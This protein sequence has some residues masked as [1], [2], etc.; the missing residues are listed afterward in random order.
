MI[1]GQE[2]KKKGR[3]CCIYVI[4]RVPD[5]VSAKKNHAPY[6]KKSVKEGRLFVIRFGKHSI[7]Q[8]K[9]FPAYESVY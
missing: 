4:L 2:V 7:C 5:Y 3:V 9:I 8:K 1:K 6:C